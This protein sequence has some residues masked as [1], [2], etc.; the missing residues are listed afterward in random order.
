MPGKICCRA[1]IWRLRPRPSIPNV[2]G[3]LWDSG[4]SMVRRKLLLG[5]SL[6]AMLLA[7]TS[8]AHAADMVAPP[9]HNWSGLYVGG[10]VGYGDLS[11]NGFFATSLDLG[12]DGAWP[13]VGARVGWNWQAGH[14]VF[15]VEGDGSFFDS[16]GD[17]LR[18]ETYTAE[19]EF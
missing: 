4:S 2:L 6:P 5:C 17:N 10:F 14:F 12:F 13:L 1:G 16:R 18:E 11:S 19:T 7:L 3:G 9:V 8:A 15:G